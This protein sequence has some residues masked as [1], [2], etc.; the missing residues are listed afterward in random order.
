MFFL[1]KCLIDELLILQEGI[2]IYDYKNQPYYVQVSVINHMYDTPALS[3]M[4]NVQCSPLCG[5]V[6]GNFKAV[7]D[8]VIYPSHRCAL[9]LEHM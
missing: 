6:S 1:R 9:P 8:S 7:A 3:K 5:L 4:M 2:T